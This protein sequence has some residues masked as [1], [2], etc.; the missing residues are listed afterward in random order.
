MGSD[1]DSASTRSSEGFACSAGRMGLMVTLVVVFA[2]FAGLS[3]NNTIPT[4]L[5]SGQQAQTAKMADHYD[6]YLWGELP[7]AARRAALQLGYSKRS[8]NHAPNYP[9]V[10]EKE[11]NDLL[12]EEQAAAKIL[13]YDENSWSDEDENIV[14]RHTVRPTESHTSEGT[15]DNT[16]DWTRSEDTAATTLQPE[17]KTEAPT[18]QGTEEDTTEDTTEASS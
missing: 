1:N 15:P 17:V 3:Q 4:G 14:T 2:V 7:K 5:R 9:P 18:E 6:N 13:G 8:W 12:P 16:P 10:F 11:W